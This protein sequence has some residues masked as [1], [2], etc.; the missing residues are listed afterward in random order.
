MKS[1]ILILITAGICGLLGGA[2]MQFLL[3]NTPA[4]AGNSAQDIITAKG[5]SLVHKDALAAYL[6]VTQDD[7]TML[8]LRDPKGRLGMIL[9]VVDQS[10]GKGDTINT[11]KAQIEFF[12]QNGDC[13]GI[14]DGTGTKLASKSLPPL[15]KGN[16]KADDP[17][18]DDIDLIWKKIFEIIDRLNILTS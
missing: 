7:R 13:V 4:F 18:Q 15:S 3:S 5:F 16:G 6:G 9:S 17:T 2:V 1:R 12:D 11:K 14:I 8:I 10:Q